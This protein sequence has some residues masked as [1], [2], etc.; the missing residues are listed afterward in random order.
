MSG[1]DQD[2]LDYYSKQSEAYADMTAGEADSPSMSRFVQMLPKGGRVLDFGSGPGWAA[3]RFRDLGFEA[4]AMDG[5]AGL[6]E[7][8]RKRYGLEIEV[9]G[10]DALSAHAEFEGIWAS[11]SL[12]HDTR[13]AMSEHL[14]R[15]HDALVPGGALYIGLKEGEGQK[16][17]ALN[18]R[19][20]Y[21][22]LPEME[23][24]LDAAS[25]HIAHHD[26]DKAMGMDGVEASCIHIFAHRD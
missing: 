4:R 7:E 21:F 16:R 1:A 25:F 12:L 22:T 26:R 20:T 6:A 8:G 13:Q 17:D 14:G 19:Y 23:R 9:C 3:A 10:F 24:L 11:F 15:L 18:R 2:T 5:S